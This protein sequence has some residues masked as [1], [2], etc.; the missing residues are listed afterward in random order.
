[1]HV[2]AC[3]HSWEFVDERLGIVGAKADDGTIIVS[4]TFYFLLQSTCIFS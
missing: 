1:M 3:V 2:Y 4:A